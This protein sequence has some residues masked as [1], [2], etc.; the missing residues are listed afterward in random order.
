M[1][2]VGYLQ[3]ARPGNGLSVVLFTLLGEEVRADVT[4]MR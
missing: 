2:Y 1:S 4:G 3:P